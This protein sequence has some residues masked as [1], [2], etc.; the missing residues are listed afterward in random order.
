MLLYIKGKGYDRMMLNSI[1]HGPLVYGIIEVDGVTRT[2][3]YEE[4]TNAEKLQDD[5][6]VS[7]T[8]IILQRL[9]PEVYSLVN[10]HEVLQLSRKRT[11]GKAMH[12]TKEAKELDMSDDLDAF[13]SD[14]DEAPGA[15]TF[16]MANLSSYE[17]IVISENVN[18]S[19]TADLERYKKMV[20]MFEESQKVNLNDR[21]KYIESQMN[22][23]ILN[24]NAKF[25]AF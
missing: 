21:E 12:S 11:Y 1:E 16:L 3:T 10:H 8:N 23:T 24:N 7:A 18:E 25:A 17:S 19:L 14:C 2:K 13:D 5:Y 4:L 15:K 20:R 22:D 6:Y 9:P